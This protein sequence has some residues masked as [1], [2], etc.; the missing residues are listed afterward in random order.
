MKNFCRIAST[1]VLL[2]LQATAFAQATAAIPTGMVE[3]PCPP[4][5]Q[6]PDSARDLLTELFM[7]PHTPTAADFADLNSNT[8]FRQYQSAIQQMGN[9]DWPALCRF[10]ADNA[11]LQAAGATPNLVFMGDSITE[12]WLLDDAMLF[13][14]NRVNRGISGQT[15]PQMLLRFR[16]D[17]VALQP[18]AVHILAGTNDVAGNTGPSTVD[19][20]K[21]NIMS[22]VELAKA[23]NIKVLLGSIPPTATFSWQP[24][25]EPVP[26]IRELNAWLRD[27][28]AEQQL[29]YIDY[30]TALTGPAGEL[31]SELGND[32]V[33]PNRDG[34]VLMRRL[35]EQALA[36]SE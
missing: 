24:T 16:A 5:V 32:G 2:G 17:V 15:T 13:D 27:Y 34:Y 14:D 11:R 12:L 22:M 29:V 10:R 19:D 26:R 20:F 8:D 36:R 7:R 6:I 25:I 28:A 21:N 9:S 1:L 23:N 31:R 18:H 33:H 30:Y 3:Q 35:L 4:P